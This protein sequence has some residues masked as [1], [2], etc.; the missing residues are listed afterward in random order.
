MSKQKGFQ[1]RKEKEPK[2]KKRVLVEWENKRLKKVYDE[3]PNNDPLKNKIEKVIEEIKKNPQYGQLIP[4]KQIPK[5]YKKKGFNYAFW[6][7][8]NSSWRL[9]YTVT[10]YNEV[11]ILAIILDFFHH[12]DYERKFNY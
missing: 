3:L 6:V 10:S 9:I 5:E 1:K 11:E 2:S 12:K 8:L 4:Q 7:H